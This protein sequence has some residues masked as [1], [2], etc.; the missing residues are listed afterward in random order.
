M[1]T[2]RTIFGELPRKLVRAIWR[3]PDHF[4]EHLV[5]I[6]QQQLADGAV[7]WATRARARD[8]LATP[9]E[10]ASELQTAAVRFARTNGA[11]A[12]TPFLT[13]LVPAY[14]SVMWEQAQMTMKIA[15]L[16]G[17]DPHEPGS[18]A[19]ILYLRGIY[20]SPDAAAQALSRLGSGKTTS[21][22]TLWAG[23]RRWLMLIYVILVLTGVLWAPQDQMREKPEQSRRILLISN[24]LAAGWFVLTSVIPITCMIDMAHSCASDTRTLATRAIEYYSRPDEY[25]K[26]RIPGRKRK[27]AGGHGLLLIASL[28]FPLGLISLAVLDPV[29]HAQLVAISGLLGPAV[30]LVLWAAASRA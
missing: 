15:A 6:A 25:L 12:G 10:L 9:G 22:S 21:G 28:G 14:M 16:N 4:S 8:P 23:L 2:G 17:R 20:E 13:A 29:H 19:E 7:A 27:R 3:D 5:L 11:L 30:V 26:A 24:G 1:T 18:A